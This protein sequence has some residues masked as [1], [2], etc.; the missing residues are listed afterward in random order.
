MRLWRRVASCSVLVL[1]CATVGMGAQAAPPVTLQADGT[2]QIG[3]RTLKCGRVRN[4]LDARLPNLGLSVPDNRL[5]V[6]NPVLLARQPETV[7]L[8]VFHHEC[9]HHHIGADELKADCWAVRQGV[10]DGWLNKTGLTQVCGSFRGAPATPTHPSGAQRC[11]NLDRCFAA[12][13]IER[14]AAVQATET[15]AASSG[16]QLLSGPRLVRDGVLR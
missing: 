11:S 15:A 14:T 2:V 3:S 6:V 1:G 5:L 7:R 4:V 12:A 9:G 10:K 16:P 8:F 13:E